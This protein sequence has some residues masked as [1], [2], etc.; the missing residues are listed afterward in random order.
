MTNDR[1]EAVDS[2]KMV[3][4]VCVCVVPEDDGKI[5]DIQRLHGNNKT[6]QGFEQQ[7]GTFGE[8]LL[9]RVDNNQPMHEDA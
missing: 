3:L 4:V 2:V 7:C 5:F 1:Q 6:Q 8:Q 9:S